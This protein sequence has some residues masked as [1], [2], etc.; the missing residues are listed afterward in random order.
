MQSKV[1]APGLRFIGEMKR[2]K[3]Q[4]YLLTFKRSLRLS[5]PTV[6]FKLSIL[7]ICNYRNLLGTSL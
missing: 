5:L 2:K 3:R 4:C 7:M 6:K 1:A